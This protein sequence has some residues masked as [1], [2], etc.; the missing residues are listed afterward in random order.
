LIVRIRFFLFSGIVFLSSLALFRCANPVSPEGGPRDITSPKVLSCIPPNFSIQFSS[1][2]IRITFNEFIALKS[3]TSEIFIS[4]PLEERP[5]YKLRGK[6]LLID[7]EKPPDSNTTY[8]INFGQSISDIT[9]GNILL[10]YRYVFSTGLYID[11]LSL[12]G[13]V[14][15][16]FDNQPVPDA[17]AELYLDN[18]DTIPFDS[19]PYLVPPIYL[20]ETDKQGMFSFSNLRPGNYKLIILED[21]S[22]DLIYNMPAE[23]IAF[24]DSLVSPW[25]IPPLQPEADSAVQD[26]LPPAPLPAHPELVLKMFEE[27]DS[28]QEVVKAELVTNNLFRII[29]KFP[30]QTPEIIPLN[31]DSSVAWCMQEFSRNKDTLILFSTTELP[32]TLILKICDGELVVDTAEIAPTRVAESKRPKKKEEEEKPEQ[33]QITW[34]ARNIY[35]YVK[36][37]LIGRVSYPLASYDLS[38][39]QLISEGD[40]MVPSIEFT[41]SLERHFKVG[42]SWKEGTQYKLVIPDSTLLSYNGLYNGLTMYT[43][44][45]VAL[46]DLGSLLLNIDLSEKPGSYIIQLLSDKGVAVEEQYLS[47]SGQVKFPFIAP[48][49]YTVKAILDTNHNKRWDTGDYLKKI[50]PEAVFFFSKPLDIRGN[51]DVEEEWKL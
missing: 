20:T 8:I 30:P 37:P 2:D 29:Y 33:L 47:E 42:F 48:A 43:F 7:F 22:G 38:K 16:A 21:K 51:W 45:T 6:T 44:K 11:S 13:K 31:L 40:S 46:R 25:Y 26:S 3:P 18:N 36:Q 17:F 41:D 24:A 32:D 28:T 5:E 12:N 9:E 15:N 14:I 34:N 49:T 35:N 1:P 10:G 50:Q 4:P 39:I 27:T 23:R 19:L